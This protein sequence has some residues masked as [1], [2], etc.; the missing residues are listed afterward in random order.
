MVYFGLI[1]LVVCWPP[2]WDQQLH[3]GGDAP[4]SNIGCSLCVSSVHVIMPKLKV[5]IWTRKTKVTQTKFILGQQLCEEKF[6]IKDSPYL[7]MRINRRSTGVPAVTDYVTS[8]FVAAAFYQKH[9]CTRTLQK[10]NHLKTTKESCWLKS[11]L[12]DVQCLNLTIHRAVTTL[13]FIS[14]EWLI[15]FTIKW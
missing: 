10:G 15:I 13:T 6:Q 3:W 4:K 9:H 14:N 7:I 5:W 11:I 12:T 2:N 8:L 1:S